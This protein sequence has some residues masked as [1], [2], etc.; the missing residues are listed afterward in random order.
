MTKDLAPGGRKRCW[1]FGI[2]TRHLAAILG[3]AAIVA[4]SV[5]WAADNTPIGKQLLIKQ[6]AS[7]KTIKI[8]SKD[9]SGLPLPTASPATTGA[10][11]EVTLTYGTGSVAETFMLPAANWKASGSPVK[12]YK[13]KDSSGAPGTIKTVTFTGGKQLKVS[14]FPSTLT[15]ANAPH[16]GANVVLTIGS[17][18]YCLDFVTPANPNT[19]ASAKW[20]AQL[21]GGTCPAPPTTSTTSTS[22]TTT[23]TVPGTCGD[24]SVNSPTE[25]CD[26]GNTDPCDGC[27]GCKFDSCGDGTV[28]A[29]EGEQCDD[30]NLTPGDGCNASCETEGSTCTSPPIGNRLVVV[31]LTTPSALSGVQIRLEYPQLQSSLPG[32]G[33]S[34]VVQNRVFFFQKPSSGITLANDSD[35]DLTAVIAG[36]GAPGSEFMHSG[37]LF[38]ANFDDCIPADQGVCNR[39]QFVTGCCNNP[40]DPNQFGNSCA[41]YT[42]TLTCEG[43]EDCPNRTNAICTGVG[44]PYSCCTGAGIGTCDST[45]CTGAGTPF[46]CCTGVGTGNCEAQTTGCAGPGTP[47]PCCTGLNTG[48]CPAFAGSCTFKCPGNPPICGINNDRNVFNFSTTVAGPCQGK[49]CSNN[50]QR[51]CVVDADCVSPGTCTVTQAAGA[52]PGESACVPQVGPDGITQCFVTDPVDALGQPIAGVSCSVTVL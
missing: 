6:S 12:V 37:V 10:A 46:A 41:G 50:S 35:T 33:T 19:A 18:R 14:G 31:S 25:Q 28:C 16:L 29:N 15:L 44:A 52:C 38:A 17:D 49:V 11:L 36:A 1:R 40:A 2:D 32:S 21:V 13:Y 9:P 48:N 23:T 22:S 43:D 39:I 42:P 47:F 34:S 8:Q 26:D 45:G 27:T 4:S 24:G 30:G 20:G 5:A 7:K 51:A 3:G